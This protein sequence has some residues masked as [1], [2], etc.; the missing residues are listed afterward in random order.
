MMFIQREGEGKQTS[1][2]SYRKA[3]GQR[4][5]H[6]YNRAIEDQEETW[7]QRTSLHS[8]SEYEWKF[9]VKFEGSGR[10]QSAGTCTENLDI[11]PKHFVYLLLI[12]RDMIRRSANVNNILIAKGFFYKAT[13]ERV[14]QDM[15]YYSRLLFMKHALF[16]AVHMIVAMHTDRVL[17]IPIWHLSISPAAQDGPLVLLNSVLGLN[18]KE[19]LCD[20]LLIF[21]TWVSQKLRC[22]SGIT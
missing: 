7:N 9:G 22:V 15:A 21:C 3:Q 16:S 20:S 17:T 19:P 11:L 14:K 2:G 10:L 1:R 8:A 5:V 18:A 12:W 6:A 4:V 13:W